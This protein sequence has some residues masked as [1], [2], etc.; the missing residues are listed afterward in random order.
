MTLQ[1]VRILP[2]HYTAS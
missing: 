1:N 2:Y